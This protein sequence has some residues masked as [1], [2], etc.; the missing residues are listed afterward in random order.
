MPNQLRNCVYHYSE[1]GLNFLHTNQIILG[2]HNFIFKIFWLPIDSHDSMPILQYFLYIFIRNR[3]YTRIPL[4]VYLHLALLLFIVTYYTCLTIINSEYISPWFR[5]YFGDF[6]LIINNSD[7]KMRHIIWFN[8]TLIGWLILFT[9]GMAIFTPSNH[10][11]QA[12]YFN[13]FGPKGVFPGQICYWIRIVNEM[14]KIKSIDYTIMNFAFDLIMIIYGN[15]NNLFKI[16]N[17]KKRLI[18]KYKK[19]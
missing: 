4:R 8:I 13:L 12:Y 14:I 18:G 15:F 19:R 10:I 1:I 16:I 11:L 9:L 17:I 7:D 6:T 3:K 5:D 2:F